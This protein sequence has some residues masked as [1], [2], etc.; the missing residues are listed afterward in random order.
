M[1]SYLLILMNYSTQRL[2]IDK[3]TIDSKTSKHGVGV[4]LFRDN[5]KMMSDCESLGFSRVTLAMFWETCGPWMFMH[6]QHDA[7]ALRTRLLFTSCYSGVTINGSKG[8]RKVIQQQQ[9]SWDR[10]SPWYVATASRHQSTFDGTH[11]PGEGLVE[12]AAAAVLRMVAHPSVKEMAANAFNERSLD[13]WVHLTQVTFGILLQMY[14][15]D[16]A[17]DA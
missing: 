13:A 9:S 12:D 3:L 8:R 17:P 16:E 11:L 5:L 6:V 7:D 4:V 15:Y 1:G 14:K 2:G 10:W